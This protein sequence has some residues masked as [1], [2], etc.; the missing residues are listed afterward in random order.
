M[1]DRSMAGCQVVLEADTWRWP[2]TGVGRYAFGLG[3]ALHGMAPVAPAMVFSV[4]ADGRVWRLDA[5]LEH[6]AERRWQDNVQAALRR[7]ARTLGAGSL[8]RA[9]SWWQSQRWQH[10]TVTRQ[11]SGT[12]QTFDGIWYA[13]NFV[14]AVAGAGRLVITVHDLSCFD[15]PEWHP[16]ERVRFMQRELPRAVEQAQAITVVSRCTEARLRALLNPQAPIV[17]APPGVDAVFSKV[18]EEV[19]QP[20]LN[21]WR[22]QK[23]RYFLCVGTLEPRKNLPTVVRAFASLPPDMRKGTPLI[24][25]GMKG[26][27]TDDIEKVVRPL[28]AEGSVRRLGFVCDSGLAALYS[29]CAGFFYLSYY[30]GFGLPPL[31]AMACGAPVVVSNTTSLPEIVGNAGITLPPDDIDALRQYMQQ[32]IDDEKQ[33]LALGSAGRLR[34]KIFTWDHCAR[35]TV[36]AFEI[37]LRHHHSP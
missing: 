33:R 25:V 5:A 30:E 10:E 37:A 31:E 21:R 18:P 14:P 23:D 12:K 1:T 27:L 4:W 16:V 32:L 17:L 34:S 3:A 22:L 11:P 19:A 35:Q 2:R 15:H 7:A 8:R 9:W 13:P 24:V 20:W 28:E 36:T 6:F 29:H 26:W